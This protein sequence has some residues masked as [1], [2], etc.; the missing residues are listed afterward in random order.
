MRS[1]LP[2]PAAAAGTPVVWAD[3]ATRSDAAPRR[4][5]SGPA[6]DSAA[7]RAQQIAQE[8]LGKGLHLE[9]LRE[10]ADAYARAAGLARS[11]SP[12]GRVPQA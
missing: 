3:G 4:A 1:L 8:R 5:P 12:K 6:G 2:V 9:P 10:A 7:F 11:P